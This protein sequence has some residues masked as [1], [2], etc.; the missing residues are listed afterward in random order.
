MC[1]WGIQISE[2]RLTESW[3][4]SCKPACEFNRT[5]CTEISPVQIVD[6]AENSN[7][8]YYRSSNIDLDYSDALLYFD[9]DRSRYIRKDTEKGVLEYY[10]KKGIHRVDVEIFQYTPYNT[11]L[12]VTPYESDECMPIKLSPVFIDSGRGEG[13]WKHK[14]ARFDLES[15][16]FCS[17]KVSIEMSGGNNG[18]ELQISRI[19][20][21]ETGRLERDPA[22][23][24][25]FLG[26]NEPS[27]GGG[28]SR[29]WWHWFVVAIGIVAACLF[30]VF[31]IRRLA[32]FFGN[33]ETSLY[34]RSNIKELLGFKKT[35]ERVE[36]KSVYRDST[37]LDNREPSFTFRR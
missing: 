27:D 8:L 29:D 25:S 18:W 32:L 28:V 19:T 35:E 4:K 7:L 30:G 10:A 34:H 17:S 16:P 31:V 26:R 22:D 6:E 33:D 9:G 21:L 5:E 15:L 13:G 3:Y 37:A 14:I 24:V 12:R 1:R 36:M 20:L 11:E 23:L 2:V